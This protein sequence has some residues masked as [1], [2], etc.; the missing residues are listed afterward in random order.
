MA[1]AHKVDANQREIVEAL[2][3]VG[4]DV[5]VM[6]MVGGGFPDLLVGWRGRLYLL[7]VKMP[8]A[9]MTAP[10][11]DFFDV[12]FDYDVHITRSASDALRVIGA[13]D[14]NNGD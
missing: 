11:S 6:S 10:E 2:R 12:W 14:G 9:A 8:G 7:E 13:V 3:A 4:A 1:Y 5:R